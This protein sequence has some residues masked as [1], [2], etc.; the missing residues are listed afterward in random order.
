MRGILK[1]QAR[2]NR[3]DLMPKPVDFD[4]TALVL[5]IGRYAVHHGTLGII[6]SPG[7][8]G[9]PVY[10]VVENHFA[11]AAASRYLSKAFAWATG[12]RDA[13]RLPSRVTRIGERL[14]RPTILIPH[15]RFGRGLHSR[16]RPRACKMVPVTSGAR[17]PSSPAVQQ[18]GIAFSV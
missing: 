17:R 6:R 15:R 1:Q 5:K 9:V 14:G 10:A 2:T 16:A 7:K 13:E 8:L 11:P 12:D 3:Q 18:E 4:V